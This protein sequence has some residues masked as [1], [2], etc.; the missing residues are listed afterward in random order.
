[1]ARGRRLAGI[2]AVVLVAVAMLA[3]ASRLHDS[4]STSPIA[5]VLEPSLVHPAELAGVAVESQPDSWARSDHRRHSGVANRFLLGLLAGTDALTILL[6]AVG[7]VA[8]ERREPA[9]QAWRA[10]NVRRRAPPRLTSA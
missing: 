7:T 2:T 1:M 4:L 3:S 8:R 10:G 6:F 9:G 5:D